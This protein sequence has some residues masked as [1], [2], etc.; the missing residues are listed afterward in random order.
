VGG[1]VICMCGWLTGLVDWGEVFGSIDN[2]HASRHMICCSGQ[3][4]DS[5]WPFDDFC[6]TVGQNHFKRKQL[7]TV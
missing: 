1:A 2:T 3:V 6:V 4:A 5:L 7:E